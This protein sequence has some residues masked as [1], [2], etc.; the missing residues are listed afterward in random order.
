MKKRENGL[1][2]LRL[3]AAFCVVMIHN[4]G[5]YKTLYENAAESSENFVPDFTVWVTAFVRA[6]NWAVPA[7]F[8]IS[9]A[10]VLSSGKTA[11]FGAFYKNTKIKLG[12]P[13]L[14]FTLIYF[15][16]IPISNYLSSPSY[17][18]GALFF[19]EFMTTLTGKPADHMWYMFTLIGMYLCAP[20]IKT[21]K[22]KLGAKGFAKVS[23]AAY[24]WGTVSLLLQPHEYFW[25]IGLVTGL[26][27]LFML[28]NV[29]HEKIGEKKDNKL[30]ALMLLLGVLST[31]AVT[32]VYVHKKLLGDCPKLV[33]AVFGKLD[34]SN[35]LISLGGM[36]F[37]AAFRLLDIK[38]DF[39][40]PAEWTFY[41]Y[42]IHPL[43]MILMN[44][45]TTPLFGLPYSV[46]G[47]PVSIAVMFVQGIVC[48]AISMIAS[49]I[50]VNVKNKKKS[51]A[52]AA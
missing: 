35:P 4:V 21:G 20:F 8:L 47:K 22:D 29:I 32:I 51:A 13:T 18:L 26:L 6:Q 45:V 23:I 52:N 5:A 17:G 9:G 44:F 37:F 10:F 41:V 7:F 49:M 38:K 43:V 46:F 25:N 12:R 28:G 34:S 42:L 48:F 40:R 2:L 39:F 30:A 33:E 11:D 27:G 50:I 1:D 15:I 24:I 19:Y 14:I 3:I 16:A 31:V 36:A